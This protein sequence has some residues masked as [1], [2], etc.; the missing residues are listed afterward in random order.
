MIDSFTETGSDVKSSVFATMFI[1]VFSPLMLTRREMKTVGNNKKLQR[2]CLKNEHST[3]RYHL[4]HKI[5]FN[6]KKQKPRRK[7]ISRHIKCKLLISLAGFYALKT[8]EFESVF[9]ACIQ[10]SHHTILRSMYTSIACTYVSVCYILKIY[11]TTCFCT[12]HMNSIFD[13]MLQVLYT[14]Y[15]YYTFCRVIQYNP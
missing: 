2:F 9:T 11:G 1:S 8:Q 3:T 15:M 5:S 14:V 12:L 4:K 6:R 10:L 13:F 7:C